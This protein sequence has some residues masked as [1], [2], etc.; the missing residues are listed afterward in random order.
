MKS[1]IP[2]TL[3]VRGVTDDQR[4]YRFLWG[5][6][7]RGFKPWLHCQPCFRGSRAEGIRPL[8]GNDTILLDRATDFFYLCGYASGPRK[9]R[10]ELNLHLAVR[11]KLGSTAVAISKY[12][13]TFTIENA[14]EIVIPE[15]QEPHAAWGDFDLRCKNLRFGAMMNKADDWG[16]HVPPNPVL[17]RRA[18]YVES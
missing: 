16:P 4:K 2:M 14:E 17:E 10:G 9:E 6:Y 7:V 15:S 13:P 3:T 12:G 5:F 18:E 1:E 8:M 11:P